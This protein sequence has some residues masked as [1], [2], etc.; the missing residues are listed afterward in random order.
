ML[1]VVVGLVALAAVFIVW[2][3]LQP[4][5]EAIAV[6]SNAAVGSAVAEAPAGDAALPKPLRPPRRPRPRRLPRKRPPPPTGPRMPR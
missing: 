5:Q 2:R 4:T 3:Q 1:Y 6:T